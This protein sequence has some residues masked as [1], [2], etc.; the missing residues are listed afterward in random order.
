MFEIENEGGAERLAN[1]M[2]I[3]RINMQKVRVATRGATHKT[4]C[5]EREIHGRLSMTACRRAGRGRLRIF[6]VKLGIA[7]R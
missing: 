3:L 5:L 2:F 4:T 7:R 6:V 1:C